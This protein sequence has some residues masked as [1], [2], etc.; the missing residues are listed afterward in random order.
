[1]AFWPSCTPIIFFK[2][3]SFF[4]FLRRRS[5]R[6][7][8]AWLGQ[9]I[10]NHLTDR[11]KWI[12]PS[13][14][15]YIKQ[16]SSYCWIVTLYNIWEIIEEVVRFDQSL[17]FLLIAWEMTCLDFLSMCQSLGI[18]WFFSNFHVNPSV[19]F[20]TMS[21][22]TS[23]DI[24]WD[25]TT[26][27]HRALKFHHTLKHSVVLVELLLKFRIFL[28]LI[29]GKGRTC[30]LGEYVSCYRFLLSDITP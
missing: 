24:F 22:C 7:W 12:F 6:N 3:I 15:R 8:Q 17:K 13:I 2:N 14:H 23:Y 19:L 28:Y 16:K 9:F 18:V 26:I 4:V 21:I 11:R 20:A 29:K 27:P 30:Y 10:D 1:M 25:D 5:I